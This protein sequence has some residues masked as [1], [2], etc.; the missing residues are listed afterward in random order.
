MR[1]FGGKVGG[2]ESRDEELFEKAHLK[3]YLRGKKYFQ[4]RG[5]VIKV[6]QNEGDNEAI[7]GSDKSDI[8]KGVSE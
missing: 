5:I 7:R 4:W 1:K 6:K 3:A 2:F 8:D